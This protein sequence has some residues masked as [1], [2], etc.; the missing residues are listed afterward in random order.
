[1]QDKEWFHG[2][3]Q[4]FKLQCLTFECW[5]RRGG[6]WVPCQQDVSVPDHYDKYFSKM[7]TSHTSVPNPRWKSAHGWYQVFWQPP[8]HSQ[9]LNLLENSDHVL[10]PFSRSL[11]A[12]TIQYLWKL[13]GHC[14]I[15]TSR[16]QSSRKKSYHW[17]ID[18]LWFDENNEGRGTEEDIDNW[19]DSK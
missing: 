12:S 6:L 16:N 1:M 2:D 4:I 14:Q 7:E 17:C 13:V 19:S 15:I 18:I 10:L 9:S 3:A 8:I 5:W 11:C